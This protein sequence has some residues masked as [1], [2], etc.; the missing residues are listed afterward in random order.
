MA[1]NAVCSKPRLGQYSSV[2]KAH[3]VRARLRSLAQAMV[4]SKCGVTGSMLRRRSSSNN[5]REH[6]SCS[7]ASSRIRLRGRGD[8]LG[9]G[10]PKAVGAVAQHVGKGP[11]PGAGG[12]EH[13]VHRRFQRVRQGRGSKR[14]WLQRP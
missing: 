8:A 11:G 12:K 1:F 14:W 13:P 9:Q 6:R 4:A 7:W 3:P 5:G 10:G 2:G